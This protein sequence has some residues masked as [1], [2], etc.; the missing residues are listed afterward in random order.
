MNINFSKSIQIPKIVNKFCTNPINFKGGREQDCLEL[1]KLTPDDEAQYQE[2]KAQT[3]AEIKDYQDELKKDEEKLST[4]QEKKDFYESIINPDKPYFQQLCDL[5]QTLKPFEEQEEEY[6]AKRQEV[7][8]CITYKAFMDPNWRE[9]IISVLKK[10]RPD[11]Q[12]SKDSNDTSK[13]FLTV[14]VEEILHSL[15]N[16]YNNQRNAELS[17]FKQSCT[18]ILTPYFT[19]NDKQ[20]DSSSLID[21]V[22]S[23][24]FQTKNIN[25]LEKEIEDC[26]EIIDYTERRISYNNEK[27]NRTKEDLLTY[28]KYLI[29]NPQIAPF[30]KPYQDSNEIYKELL[31]L[32]GCIDASDVID[33]DLQSIIYTLEQMGL[34]KTLS[35]SCY[36][37]R[38]PRRIVNLAKKTG[39]PISQ[40]FKPQGKSFTLIDITDETSKQ[41]VQTLMSKKGRLRTYQQVQKEYKLPDSYM[42]NAS[43]P[44]VIFKSTNPNYNQYLSLIE[45][46]EDAIK[47]LEE[48]VTRYQRTKPVPLDKYYCSEDT[49]P[50]ERYIPATL[51]KKLGFFSANGLIQL[52]KNRKLQG[53]IKQI[54]T[55]Q[56]PRTQAYIDLS[57]PGN[58]QILTKLRDKNK[59]TLSLNEFAKASG[60]SQKNLME[61][62]KDG[63]VDIIK[64]VIFGM[65]LNHIYIDLNIEKNRQFLF[66]KELEQHLKREQEQQERQEKELERINNK[67][68]REKYA[69]LRMKLV[70]YFCPKTKQIASQMASQDGYL[71]K[72]LKKDTNDEE[73][74]QREKIKI[75]SYRKNLWLAAGTDELK[76]GFKKADEILERL[77][78]SGVDS[79]ED[80]G[81]RNII[82]MY[83]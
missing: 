8:D 47:A 59:T 78:T 38:P 54:E 27:I 66:E 67:D 68:L 1:Q 14:L 79:I 12:N 48:Q 69:S 60:I 3:D 80:E 34:L 23:T 41:T 32:G 33:S 2:Q 31:D 4:Y 20:D 36:Y 82:T 9:N 24:L 43:L 75:N 30:Y 42:Q 18:Q 11:Y 19:D 70:W 21:Y 49:P 46:N 74:T 83:L 57:A 26:T 56:G 61:N 81:I 72:L 76:E 15:D 35:H 50:K 22:S 17:R 62:I 45:L 37:D 51:L 40:L 16:D 39:T 63:T 77:K 25:S 71:C 52:V 13:K 64:E 6:K 7:H 58:I 29:S 65:D 10:Y 28:R 53:Y 44:K 5:I 55:N 73:L